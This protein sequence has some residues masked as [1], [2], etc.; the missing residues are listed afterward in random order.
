MR[1]PRGEEGRRRGGE[2]GATAYPSSYRKGSGGVEGL[3]GEHEEGRGG[4]AAG[5]G[6]GNV[7]KRGRR[8]RWR[9]IRGYGESYK[10]VIVL[11]LLGPC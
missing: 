5:E 10:A 6:D 1:L 9:R 8:R 4:E 7:P 2:E 11:I 3:G